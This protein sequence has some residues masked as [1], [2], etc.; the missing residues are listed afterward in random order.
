MASVV[1][2]VSAA[3]AI[4]FFTGIA[5]AVSGNQQQAGKDFL[6]LP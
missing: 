5:P 2:V 3:D 1:D 4:E 6:H